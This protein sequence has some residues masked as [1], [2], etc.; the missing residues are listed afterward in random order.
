MLVA[1]LCVGTLAALTELRRTQ[2][3][4]QERQQV[5]AQLSEARV[6]L[7]RLIADTFHL[8]AGLVVLAQVDGEVSAERF[9]RYFDTMHGERP[10][11]R[12]VVV[13]PGDVVQLV[14]PLSGNERVL[15]LDYRKVPVQWAQLE[16]TRELGQPL[17]F[18][19]VKLV[20]GGQGVIQ[21]NPVFVIDQ[22]SRRYWGSVS[23]VADLERFLTESRLPTHSLDLQL[24]T[25]GTDGRPAERL[26]GPETLQARAVALTVQLPGA[27]WLLQGQ[28]RG[29]WTPAPLWLDPAT[30]GTALGCL[31]VTGLSFALGQ[32]RRLLQ[33][34]N[35]ELAHE[36]SQRR[37]AHAEAED[38][39]GRLQGLLDLSSDW[40]WEQD[41]EL[42]LS[43]LSMGSGS[44]TQELTP[45]IGK[46]R[47]ET[48]NLLPGAAWDQHRATLA[49]RE[50]FRDFEYA[51]RNAQGEAIYVSVS[52]SPVFDEQGRF[53]GYRG[54]GRDISAVRRTEQ[55]LRHS[56]DE[57]AQAHAHVREAVQRLQAVLD[58][59]VEVGIITVDLE[60]R[61]D[62]FSRGAERLLGCTAAEAKGVLARTFHLQG[63]VEAEA[64][65]LA[66]RLGRPTTRSE[67][68]QRQA[69]GLDG[70]HH[71]VWTYVRRDNG[72]QLRVSHTFT[73]LRDTQ[74]RHVGYLAVVLDMSAQLRA[75][76]ATAALKN[77]L[78]TVLDSAEDIGIVAMSL[79]GQIELFNRGAERLFGYR[80]HEVLGRDALML[81]D[82]D[83]LRRQAELK[84]QELGRKVGRHEMFRLTLG[85]DGRGPLSHWIYVRK[86]GERLDGA[87]RFNEMRDREGQAIGYLAICMDVSDQ[88]R[89]RR[90]L[91]GLNA[92]LEAR[93]AGRTAELQNALTTLQ[94]A[95]DELLRSEKMAALGSLVAGVAHELN[96]PIGNCLTA[97]S[98]LEERTQETQRL[99]EQNALKRSALESYLREAGMGT[100][101][102]LRGLR[103]A[104]DL[105]THF[106]QVSVDQTS[107]QRR[108]FSL[109]GVAED[110]ISVLRPQ[111][112][113]SRV[114]LDLDLQLA[115]EIDGY[116]GAFG[117]LLTNLILNANVHAFEG[118]SEPCLTLQSREL[119]PGWFELTVRDNGTGMSD[120]VRRRAFDP[121][122]TTKMGQGGTGLGLN[123][124]YNIATGVLGGHVE[125]RSSPG[126]G[127]AF[128]FR[129]PYEA[130]QQRE[131]AGAM[132]AS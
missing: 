28:P 33:L 65:R 95:Q 52:G 32:R 27:R 103:S 12:N 59:A 47:W 8:S 87:L 72:Q 66:E 98:T 110:V 45:L 97:A 79:G 117:Q 121:F 92:Q 127:T 113:N 5:Q 25:L 74:G 124:V 101:L 78:Q 90:E 2:L 75:Q 56:G 49:R 4:E 104:V 125:L 130:P 128:V 22:G 54:T 16:R 116:P 106:K 23:L 7:D 11:L 112:K 118:V 119:E 80:A 94:Q 24:H 57:L 115:Q 26:F 17:I 105:V 120:E 76:E 67:T 111:L 126:E 123:I 3:G 93:V 68:F 55:A 70:G 84:S 6:R 35:D 43:Y 91:E 9:A 83:E 38:A 109:A 15:G 31:L 36:V 131:V 77:Q 114:R 46:R 51:F 37:Q 44:L 85:P 108:R 89:A 53:K 102:L 69:E 18:G 73:E 21:R 34:R 30:L 10:Q 48:Q 132:R 1:L 13:A 19:P 100:Q 71:R 63:E 14:H 40:L 81:H 86:G 64:Q 129:L 62:L 39:R 29:G 20:Q 99:F 96:T 88:V 61:V 107:E 82:P 58:S 60:G 41:A 42:R 50:P 122:F